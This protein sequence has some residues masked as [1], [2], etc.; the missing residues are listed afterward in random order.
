MK[1]YEIFHFFRKT[2]VFRLKEC[3]VI[4]NYPIS[5]R[6][7]QFFSNVQQLTAKQATL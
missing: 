1:Y 2:N 6:F 3:L 7:L 5:T 4:S